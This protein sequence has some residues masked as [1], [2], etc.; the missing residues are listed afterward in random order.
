MVRF[1][2]GTGK[3]LRHWEVSQ[4]L[5]RTRTFVLSA[6][7]GGFDPRLGMG[8]YEPGQARFRVRQAKAGRIL[9][10]CSMVIFGEF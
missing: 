6:G 1:S 4:A 5:R 8:A 3:F 9:P 10:V 7:C 2:S